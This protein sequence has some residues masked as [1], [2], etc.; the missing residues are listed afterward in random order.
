MVMNELLAFVLKMPAL[1]FPHALLCPGP[2]HPFTLPFTHQ[3][4]QLLSA[5]PQAGSSGGQGRTLRGRRLGCH[6]KVGKKLVMPEMRGRVSQ[7]EGTVWAKALNP[8]T[9]NL[10]REGHP[11]EERRGAGLQIFEQ[12]QLRTY[13]Q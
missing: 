1:H 9:L 5:Q 2:A 3:S 6:L 8:V 10:G 4:C 11:E 12:P 13:G 7:R